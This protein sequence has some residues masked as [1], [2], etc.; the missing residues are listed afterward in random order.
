MPASTEPRSASAETHG[1]GHCLICG[2]HNPFSLGARFREDRHG[3][4]RAR[5]KA[6]PWF[7]G[8]E[9]ILHGGVISGPLDSAMT[10]CLL[11]HGVRAVT[12][13]LRVRFL[14]PVRCGAVLDVRAHPL[15]MTPPLYRSAAAIA[16][17]ARVAARAEAK[18][19][20]CRGDRYP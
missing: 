14:E 11:L 3:S 10:H 19:M 13:D 20:R 5:F 16:D 15:E 7:Q 12:G 9:G 8:Y 2:T 17:D 4:V 6:L 1:H 18:F